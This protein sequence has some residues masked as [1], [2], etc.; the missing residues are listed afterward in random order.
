MHDKLLDD[1]PLLGDLNGSTS[2]VAEYAALATDVSQ[3][4]CPTASSPAVDV[5]CQMSFDA[6]YPLFSPSS[7]DLKP[8]AERRSTSTS[9]DTN[10]SRVLNRRTRDPTLSAR[11]FLRR[12]AS[13][14][15][16][17]ASSSSWSHPAPHGANAARPTAGGG[18]AWPHDET[19]AFL[20]VRLNP[21]Q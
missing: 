17:I 9:E 1:P 13:S 5:T 10:T 18:F 2:T 14:E 15:G 7:R 8:E 12:P 16:A 21:S 6:A 11:R 19:N 4:D 20:R 3:H